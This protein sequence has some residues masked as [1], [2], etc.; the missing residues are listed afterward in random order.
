M[1]NSEILDYF[2]RHKTLDA[3][4]T[5]IRFS[6]LVPYLKSFQNP[7]EP[8]AAIIFMKHDDPNS[9]SLS[10]LLRSEHQ[11]ISKRL[12]INFE[13]KEYLQNLDPQVNQDKGILRTSTQI[14]SCHNINT[15]ENN[16]YLESNLEN[17][18][19]KEMM[20]NENIFR[21]LAPRAESVH[22]KNISVF[23]NSGLSTLYVF[24]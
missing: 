18:Y 9:P 16:D 14:L 7:S 11:A 3:Q 13:D 23:Y 5:G 15:T 6:N 22:S 17:Y 1:A 19:D 24:P 4:F 12:P 8:P 2:M 21:I 10:Y 20:K